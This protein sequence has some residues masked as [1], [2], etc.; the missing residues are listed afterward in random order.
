MPKDFAD[1]RQERIDRYRDRADAAR[2]NSGALL[3]EARTMADVIPFGQ[4]ILVGHH[5]EQRDRNYRNRIH[6]K[7]GKAF[8]EGNRADYWDGRA[9]AAE[10]NG[11]ISSDDPEAV[12]QLA[13][14]IA[15][16]EKSQELMKAANKIVRK[17]KL[18]D[19]EKVGLLCKDLK[20]S[21]DTA[22]GL[23]VPDFANRVG[24][25]SYALQNNNANIRRMKQRLEQL[26]AAAA[27]EHKETAYSGFKVVENP[28]ENRVQFYF[29]E[30]PS[31]EVRT[32]LKR[33]GF[34]FSKRNGNAWQR[35]LNPR[36]IWVAESAA[37]EIAPLLD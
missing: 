33:D 29:D 30:K 15:D 14:K 9:A 27:A 11:A 8:S 2:T 35:F 6:N 31:A 7:F 10:S 37:K 25:A 3:N 23:L 13:E 21:E 1:R 26:K 22:R 28:D 19:E 24:F 12:T 18:S 4:P 17:K 36:S 32:I 20:L 16:A 5:S 34:K